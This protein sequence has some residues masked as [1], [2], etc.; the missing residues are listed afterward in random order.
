MKENKTT[1]GWEASTTGEEKTS[2][3][4]LTLI[5]LHTIK[6]LNKKY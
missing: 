4:R 2:N 1:R 6:F 5:R 3:Q